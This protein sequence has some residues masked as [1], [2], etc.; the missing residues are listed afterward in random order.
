M[1][2][3][4]TLRFLAPATG[5]MDK[6]FYLDVVAEGD[7]HGIVEQLQCCLVGNGSPLENFLQNNSTARLGRHFDEEEYDYSYQLTVW[8]DELFLFAKNIK[9][10]E[11]FNYQGTL[12]KYIEGYGK[13]GFVDS[14]GRIAVYRIASKL[15]GSYGKNIRVY[16]PEILGGNSYMAEMFVKAIKMRP[17]RKCFAREFLYRN[18]HLKFYNSELV[19]NEVSKKFYINA[20]DKDGTI[21]VDFSNINGDSFEGTLAEYLLDLGGVKLIGNEL[22]EDVYS[23][24]WYELHMVDESYMQGYENSSEH[25]LNNAIALAK[26]LDIYEDIAHA[27][28]DIKKLFDPKYTDQDPKELVNTRH[29]EIRCL[30]LNDYVTNPRAKV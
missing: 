3:T 4:A 20:N 8:G 30:I 22:E 29:R 13:Q 9:A 1:A 6:D 12:A 10:K 27:L 25:H 7:P 14:R 18:K 19:T 15:T 24:F 28:E 21:R 11:K 26:R 2:T 23:C 17:G 5:V 16:G